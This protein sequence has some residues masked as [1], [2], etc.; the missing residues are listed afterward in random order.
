MEKGRGKVGDF[1]RGYESHTAS[2]L[3]HPAPP[4]PSVFVYLYILFMGT[5]FKK[6]NVEIVVGV[7]EGLVNGRPSYSNGQ[8]RVFYYSDPAHRLYAWT[9]TDAG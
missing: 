3:S 2:P 9:V 5:I 7:Q 1:L 8:K 4:P 6:E